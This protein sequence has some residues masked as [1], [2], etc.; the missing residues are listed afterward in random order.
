[1][2]ALMFGG[3]SLEPC[4]KSPFVNAQS[5]ISADSCEILGQKQLRREKNLKNVDK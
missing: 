5:L 2:E 4:H 3:H 1:M